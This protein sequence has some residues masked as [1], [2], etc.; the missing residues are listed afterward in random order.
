MVG[1]GRERGGGIYGSGG[2]EESEFWGI[3][4]ERGYSGCSD[5][6]ETG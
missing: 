1:V 2:C 4:A 6:E 3:G 5:I